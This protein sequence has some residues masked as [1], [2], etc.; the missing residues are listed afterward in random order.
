M[1]YSQE[2]ISASA[3]RTMHV[4]AEPL[5]SGQISFRVWA[6]E[7]RRLELVLLD[8]A[9][10]FARR[11]PL[12]E[13]ADGYYSFISPTARVGSH[14]F[15]CL[16][17]QEQLLPDPASRFQ[18]DGPHGPSEVIDP[19]S[20]RWTDQQWPGI[21]L[22]G[23]VLYEM[24]VGTFTEEGT[25]DAAI[26]QLDELSRIGI[27]ALEVMP[28][29]TFPGRFGWSYD[30][31]NL[32]SPTQ[33]YGRPD[34]FRRFV[35]RAHQCGMGVLLD[36]VYNHLGP[37]G[38]YLPKFS[39]D[40]FSKKHATDWGEAINFDGPNSDHVRS[41]YLANAA[42]WIR[43][44]H[45]DGLRLDAT[46]DIHDDSPEHILAAI[47]RTAR[48][49]V[50][51]SVVFIAENEPQHSQLVRPRESGGYGL[52]GLWN[53][54]FHHAATVLLSG[55]NEAYYSDYLGTSQEFVA[56]VKYGFLFQGQWYDWQDNK[57]G[58]PAWD[59]PPKAFINFIQNH[60]QIANS[61]LG[62]R[63]QMGTS[64]GRYKAMTA[65][66]ILAPQ[67]PMLFQ[68][69][70]FAATS[71]F[72]Y[73]AD[74]KPELAQRIEEGRKEFL[75]QFPTIAR[76]ENQTKLPPPGDTST[77]ERSK[78]KFDERE[79]HHEL[80]LLHQDLLR[81]RREDPTFRAQR[82]GSVDGAVLGDKAFVLRFF[83]Q[84]NED[85]LLIVNFDSDLSLCPQPEP[86]LSPV[87][88]ADWEL[89][90]T[91]EELKYGGGGT[92]PIETTGNWIVPGQSAIVLKPS[93]S[94]K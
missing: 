44:Y 4:G 72:F 32:F 75:S 22:E 92:P 35:D 20:F 37:D 94:N 61:A 48:D 84:Q 45:L 19:N 77:F 11:E 23:Q 71:P 62:L 76:P 49:A 68:G 47:S 83:G 87:E 10:K 28:I 79:T 2:G 1:P 26:K 43:E 93:Q 36:V 14:Y 67:T 33:L 54:D 69:Q 64:P 66:M 8:D 5:A 89:M 78:L 30:G 53:D 18:P 51:R 82:K 31:V 63:C 38:N 7:A 13:E 9:G 3:A 85:R 65:L 90:W 21:Q 16:D 60:D 24:H 56:S 88:D 12:H 70:E 59:L 55:R 29:A 50:Q 57:R 15:Y 6:P 46:Q 58:K 74:H 34:D 91:S 17:Q 81:L 27:T 86:L 39:R 73:F 42:Y 80:Y 41:Y 40:Y 25:W 52:D